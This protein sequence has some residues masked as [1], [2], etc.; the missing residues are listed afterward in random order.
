MNGRVIAKVNP[1]FA[2]YTPARLESVYRQLVEKLLDIPGVQ[3]AALA[4]YSPMEGNNWSSGISIEGRPSADDK[5]SILS[6]SWDR[7]SARHFE[8]IGTKLLRGRA[9]DE[10]DTPN[11]PHVAVVNQA[12]AEAFFHNEDP[13]GRHFGI[14]GIERSHDY[15]IVGIVGDAKYREAREPAWKMFFLPLLQMSPKDWSESGLARSNYIRDIELRVSANAS[16]LEPALRQALASVDPNVT[17]LKLESF[18]DQLRGNFNQER[19]LAR[20][21]GLYGLLALILASVGIYGVTAYSVVR[22]TSEI[23]IRMALGAARSE[24]IRMVLRGA[25]CQVGV[26]LLI[27][28]PVAIAGG[29]VLASQ[30]YGVHGYDPLMLTAAVFVLALCAMIAGIIPAYRAAGIDPLQALRRE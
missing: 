1:A 9:F 14:G 20:L 2:G 5:G 29:R 7:V 15:E 19:L 18:E 16:G 12:F 25:A 30:L 8:T 17:L 26:G 4:L 10:R 27:G 13:I 22:R 23:G 3:N 28:V 21:T 6:A 11:A 24:V